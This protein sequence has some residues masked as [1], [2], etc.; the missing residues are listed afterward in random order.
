MHS[1]KVTV[2]LDKSP[3]IPGG[4]EGYVHVQGSIQVQG[5]RESP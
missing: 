1:P 2:E 4:L 3:Q 5:V